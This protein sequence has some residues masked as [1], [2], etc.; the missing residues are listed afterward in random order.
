M[1]R[2]KPETCKVTRTGDKFTLVTTF[3]DGQ[4]FKFPSTTLDT[5]ERILASYYN[6]KLVNKFLAGVK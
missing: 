5:V 2:G 4:S 3:P 1:S 6:P